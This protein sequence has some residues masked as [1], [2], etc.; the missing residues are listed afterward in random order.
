MR[1]RALILLATGIVAVTA[2]TSAAR[3]S[4]DASTAPTG[5]EGQPPAHTIT[6]QAVG[7]VTGVP[8]VLSVSFNVHTEGASANDTLRDNSTATQQVIDTAHVAG[9]KDDDVRTTSVSITPR[10]DT[11]TG[12]APRIVGYA[13]DNAFVVKLRDK[14][15]I[16]QTIDALSAAG[17]DAVQVQGIAY[18]FDDDTAL[19]DAAR[20]DAVQ[21][22]RGQAQQMADAAG[23]HLAGVRTITELGSVSP[24]PY[25]Y[26]SAAGAGASALDATAVPVQAGTQQLTLS[27]EVVF[28]VG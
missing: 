27:V 22:A 6:T 18:S 9:V 28:D 24:G 19:L 13:A 3:A 10:Y 25:P 14:S 2:C 21:R 12:R 1:T 11:P 15:T 4:G 5:G 20:K 23:L 26:A 7:K 16:G 8:D 17:G